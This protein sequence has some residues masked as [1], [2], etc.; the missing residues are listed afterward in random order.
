MAT[1]LPFTNGFYTSTVLPISHQ[2][3]LNLYP[4]I[5]TAPALS[6]AQL[7]FTPGI[8]EIANTGNT[9]ENNRGSH[10]KNKIPY[11]VNGNSLYRINK[12]TTRIAGVPVVSYDT[13]TLGTVEGVG[14]VSIAD[15][16]TQ[17]MVLVPGGKGYIYNEDAGTPFQEIT[18]ADFTANGEP[19]IVVFVD[20][21][22]LV[23]TDSKK[24]IISAPND[25]LS[26][27]ALAFGTAES[28]PD[29][30]VAPIVLNN[31]VYLLGSETTEGFQNVPSA[32]AMP[33][34]RNNVIIDKGCRAPFSLV[35]SNSSFFMIGSGT[36]EAPAVWQFIGNSYR[37][38]STEAIEQLLATYTDEE[39]DGIYALSYSE[40]GSYFITFTLP[41]RTLCF[42]VITERW[43]ERVS[44]EDSK[45]IPWRVSSIIT[46]YG[47]VI[48][49][50][51]I[52]GRV[53][54]MSLD[55]IKEYDSN[56]IRLFT[57]QPF[58]N[59]GNELVVKM[60]ELTVESGSGN[61]EIPN[62]VV[63][64]SIS[65]DAKVFINERTRPMGKV[66]EYG[67]RVIWYRNGRCDRF[68]VFQFRLSEPVKSAFIKLEFE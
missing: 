66:G 48:V 15:N 59:Q 20:S 12:I 19:Q 61:A 64:L 18:D 47:I 45:D 58:S 11:I 38:K 6:D 37:K 49:G 13:T 33:F 53:G 62:P 54:Q 21:Y 32:G 57:T 25:G 23:T 51:S 26:W 7:L 36:D 67:R 68:V 1:A 16:G 35:K 65:N 42:D 4:S 50:D 10:V 39:I 28:D 34:I 40:S 30:I 14:R 31:T 46:A 63:S 8:S 55:Y 44:I 17:L 60:L 29:I 52:D 3:C 2:R 56:I 9:L 22:F 27:N 41:D 43:H 24:F 5:P